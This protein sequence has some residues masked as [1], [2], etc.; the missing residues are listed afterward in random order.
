[1]SEKMRYVRQLSAASEGQAPGR[2]RLRGRRILVVGGGQRTFDAATDPVG[3]GRAMSM[4]FAREGAHVAVADLHRASADDTVK[5]I[6]GE[7]G[8]AFS[9]KA[10][11]AREAD[12]NRMIDEAVDGL[13]GLDGMVLNVGIGVGALGLDGVDLKEWNDTF[14]VNLT[15]PMLCCRKALK[16]I[17]DGASIVFISSIAGAALGLAAGCLR[18]LEGGA[19]RPDAQCRQGRRA[20][21]HPRQHH[22][23]RTG[24][25]AARPSHQ[26]RPGFPSKCFRRPAP[27]GRMATGWEIAY[28]ALFFMSDESVYVNAQTLAVDSG[29]TGL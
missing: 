25:Y 16:H 12:V 3:N 11:I 8:L 19:W 22:L 24:R 17:A 2:G 10:D 15:G 5:R 7:G 6:A 26:R 21:R 18:H 4:L 14:A 13:G 9:I 1:M 28:A 29:I 27:F 23:P 20:P